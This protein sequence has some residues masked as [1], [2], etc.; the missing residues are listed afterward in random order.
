MAF[1]QTISESTRKTR[2]KVSTHAHLLGVIDKSFVNKQSETIA[3]R[4]A[5]LV[6]DGE[7]FKCSVDKIVEFSSTE[8]EGDAELDIT[9]RDGKLKMRLVGFN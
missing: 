3:Y 2:M 5:T 1:G 8:G 7:V 4:E 9:S 6:V